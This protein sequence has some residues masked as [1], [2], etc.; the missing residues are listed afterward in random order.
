VLCQE[1]LAI[2]T[3][4]LDRTVDAHEEHGGAL[5][6]LYDLRYGDGSRATERA[7]GTGPLGEVVLA[8]GTARAIA[9]GST[10]RVGTEQRTST[11]AVRSP[12]GSTS[13]TS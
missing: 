12:G 13:S 1:P 4:G 3:A 5:S 6:G 8:G 2:T 9:T 10:A 7:A 11:A